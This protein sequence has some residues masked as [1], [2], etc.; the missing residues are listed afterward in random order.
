MCGFIGRISVSGAPADDLRRGLPW[1]SRR[2]PDSQKVWS[3][4][5]GRAGILFCRLSIVDRDPRA[6]QPLTAPQTGVTVGMVGEIYNYLELRK[7]FDGYPFETVSDTEIV[8]AA[9]AKRGIEGI[10]LLKGMFAFVLV[11]ER[12]QKILLVR[13]AVG[14][15]PLFM[16]RWGGDVLFGS[17][18]LPL[19]AVHR[20]SVELETSRLPHYWKHTF[21]DPRSSALAG[22]APVLPGQVI[23]LDWSGRSVRESRCEPEPERLYDGEPLEQAGRHLRSL[24]RTAV[25]R[26]LANNPSPIVLLS[27]GVDST[28]VTSVAKPLASP[29]LRALTLGSLVPLTYDE[30]Y[31]RHAA[32]R[33]GVGLQILKPSFGSLGDSIVHALDLQ[34]EPLGMP[35]YFLLERLTRAAAGHGRVL[36]SG[37]GGDE[38]FLGYGN[39]ADWTGTG[40]A[41]VDD[42]PMVPCG[43]AL[44]G[45][46]SPWARETVTNTL[47]GHMFAKADRATAEQGVELRSPLLDWDVIAYARSLPFGLLAHDGVGKALL[48]DQLNGWPI[49]FLERPK[50]GFTYN[51]R[52]LWGISGYS[53]MRENIDERAL[54]AFKPLLPQSLRLPASRWATLQI[55]TH[56]QDAWKLLAWS[57]FLNR[58]DLAR[59]ASRAN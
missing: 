46:M 1:I 52:W 9:Y 17:S 15:K 37:E 32:R 55:F 4:S 7:S 6:H 49:W 50:A 39:T 22:A 3:S 21:I 35:S 11:D 47:V 26:R 44:P 12:A 18:L 16:A 14:K 36:L 8:L 5:D 20:G 57:R 28:L 34:D 59:A 53:G 23:E 2:G 48:K 43:P 25:E 42:G 41:R 29:P 30:R 13:D 24:I 51:L 10:R 58:F 54:E 56:F 45:W 38:F 33:I 27:G 40:G 19:V 31:A